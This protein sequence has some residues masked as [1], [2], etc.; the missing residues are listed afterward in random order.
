[1]IK[2]NTPNMVP[3]A[4]HARWL[5]TNMVTMMADMDPNGALK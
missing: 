2:K 5:M 4:T 3:D 1:M